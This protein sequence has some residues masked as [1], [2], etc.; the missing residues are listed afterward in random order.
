VHA[1]PPASRASSPSCAM[2]RTAWPGVLHEQSRPQ[3]ISARI[4]LWVQVDGGHRLPQSPQ[5]PRRVPNGVGLVETTCSSGATTN[6]GSGRSAH[7]AATGSDGCLQRPEL[8]PQTEPAM[9]PTHFLELSTSTTPCAMASGRARW[10][11]S[12]IRPGTMRRRATGPT[13]CKVT[14]TP[15]R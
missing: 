4:P 15:T 1:W 12:P 7:A 8:L 2:S 6:V 13:I 3:G 9:K 5:L 11:F 10:P 14:A